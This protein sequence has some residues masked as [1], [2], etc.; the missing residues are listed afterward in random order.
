MICK[1]FLTTRFGVPFVV[2]VPASAVID[3]IAAGEKVEDWKPSYTYRVVQETF[4]NTQRTWRFVETDVDGKWVYVGTLES[5]GDVRLTAGSK[6]GATKPR[7]RIAQRVIRAIFDGR[8]DAVTKAG[9]S[10]EEETKATQPAALP[11]AE[12]QRF[13]GPLAFLADTFTVAVGYGLKRPM[14]RLHFGDRRFKFYLSKRGTVCLKTG[15]LTGAAED[16]S[17]DPVGDEQ[18]AGC[19]LRGQFLPAKVGTE[20]GQ[21]GKTRE[22]L[23][24]EREF[25]DRL[26]KDAVGFIAQCGKDM[27]RCCYCGQPLEDVR[28]KAVG[29]GEVCAKRWG[30]PWGTEKAVENAPSFAKSYDAN[31]AALLFAARQVKNGVVD[32]LAWDVFADWLEEKG[33]PRCKVPKA[34]VTLPRN[35]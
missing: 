16:G 34:D 35:D 11:V 22:L 4:A 1:T 33:L 27:C 6:I 7:V 23:P 10:A 15:E 12:P 25:I 19:L 18:Y 2:T 13:T 21:P 28:S 8:G 31:A 20:G 17:R 14:L 9:Y 30:L 24:T 5:N 29:Y 26:A 3:A 32:A